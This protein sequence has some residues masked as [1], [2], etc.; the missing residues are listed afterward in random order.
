M[1]WLIASYGLKN[2]LDVQRRLKAATDARDAAR[3]EMDRLHAT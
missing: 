2:N 1:V 3:L